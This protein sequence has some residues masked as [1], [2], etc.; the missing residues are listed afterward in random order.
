MDRKIVRLNLLSS[1]RHGLNRATGD[2]ARY[3]ATGNGARYRA[4]GNGGCYSATRNDACYR[5][6]RNGACYSAVCD[7]RANR[8]NIRIPHTDSNASFSFFGFQ[9]WSLGRKRNIGK[10]NWNH[11]GC[12]YNLLLLHCFSRSYGRP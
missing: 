3:S 7:C 12:F 10:Q 5:A 6:T 8:R 9:N 1:F 4:T 11:W 2:S